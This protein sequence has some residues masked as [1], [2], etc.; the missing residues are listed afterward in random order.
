M[1]Y[2]AQLICLIIG[3]VIGIAIG[4][5]LSMAWNVFAPATAEWFCETFL[6]RGSNTSTVDRP[7]SP[8]CEVLVSDLHID[9]WDYP[10]QAEMRVRSFVEF[11]DSVRADPRI[12][13]FVLNGDLMDIPLFAGDLTAEQNRLML[14]VNAGP[15]TPNQ[16]VIVEKYAPVLRAL[17]TLEKPDPSGD[18]VSRAIFQTGNHD[19]GVVGLRY[20]MRVMPDFLPQV[21]AGWSPQI[22]LQG[23]PGGSPYNSRW[24]YIEHGQDYDP[25]LWLYMRYAVLDLLRGGHLHREAY[26]IRAVQR[27]GTMG[28]GRSSKGSKA[29]NRLRAQAAMNEAAG[30]PPPANMPVETAPVAR[31]PGQDWDFANDD[32]SFFERLLMLRY[33]WAGRRV[34]A[35][36]P[37]SKRDSVKTVTFGHTHMPDRYVFPGGR[38]YINSGDWCGHTDH[39]CYS[40][41]H[42]DG[43]VSGPFQW[44][45]QL[46]STSQVAD[47][48]AGASVRS[49][50][51]TR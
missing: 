40:L 23:G 43:F 27:K 38:V 11:L 24:V 9:T 41:I 14:E 36:L 8:P 39:Q 20:V 44:D 1:I 19:I 50:Q 51:E 16:G 25:F 12:E 35:A 3:I 37:K 34:F 5:A 49:V 7:V 29:K 2:I 22:L 48:S 32:H 10:P 45:G 17:I 46:R 42:R 33:R 6:D 26:F 30:K 18:N 31:A 47:D 15:I 4:L 28:L 21:Q 13:G